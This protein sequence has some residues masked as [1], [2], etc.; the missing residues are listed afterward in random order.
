[1][2]LKYVLL[3]WGGTLMVDFPGQ[4]GPMA[5]WS[6]VEAIPHAVD[7]LKGLRDSGLHIA[8]ATNAADSDESDI[9]AALARV[10]LDHLIDRVYCSRGVGHAKP[11]AAFFGF[12]E[13]DLGLPATDLV[14]V[15]DNY[16]VDVLGANDAGIRAVWLH[17]G[18]GAESDTG[19]RR[20]IRSLNEL[21]G[22]LRAWPG[23]T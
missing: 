6:E 9:R 23:T 12:I 18:R 8:L 4:S 20:S 10:G 3:D 2:G 21:P 17:D 19:M 5:D 16:D 7:T 14:M 13:R 22:V 1:M 11:S 15:G